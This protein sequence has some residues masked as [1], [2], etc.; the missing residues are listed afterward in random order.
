MRFPNWLLTAVAA[1][2]T[3]AFAAEAQETPPAETKA[4]PA[5]VPEPHAQASRAQ[6]PHGAP[7][8][9][10]SALQNR[11]QQAVICEEYEEAARLR[12][13]IESLENQSQS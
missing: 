2:A 10:L 13:E 3:T 7:D 11:L 12:D 1:A 8:D 6:E 5:P 9:A 4:E